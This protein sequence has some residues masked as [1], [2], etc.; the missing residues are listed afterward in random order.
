MTADF[1]PDKGHGDLEFGTR[2]E[3]LAERF[4]GAPAQNGCL[5][6]P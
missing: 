1:Q 5:A 4:A 6:T 2:V 3:W